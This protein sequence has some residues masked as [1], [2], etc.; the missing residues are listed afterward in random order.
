MPQDQEAESRLPIWIWEENLILEH[1]VYS[2][3]KVLLITN[4]LGPRAGGIE[5]F[6]LG[7]IEGLPKNSLII[8][9]SS[10]KGDKAFDAQLLEK[11]GAVVI[12][13]RA[14]ML[15]PTPRITRK[16]VT[17]LRQQQIKNVWFGAAAPLALM[18]GKLRSAGASNIV[19]LT[20]GHEVWWAKIP[21]LQSLLKK[22]IRDV[23]HLGYLGEFTK[24]EIAK[25]G[26]QPQKF[27]Q[28]APGIDTQHFAPK[29]ARVDLIE[30][31]RLD[32]RRVIVSVG[33]LVHRKGQDE[34]VKAMPKILKQFPDAI[35]LF[36]GEG[37]I[38]QMLFNSAKQLGVLPKV[39]FAGRVSHHDLPDY[40]CLGEIFAM[41][42]RSRFSG[43]EVEGLGIVYLEASACGLPVIVGNSGGAVDAVLDRKTGLLVDGTNCDQ[44]ADAICELLANP[45][46]A[47]QMGAAGRDWVIKNWQLSSWSEKFN[48]VLIGN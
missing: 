39:V 38:K 6:V 21:I 9:T 34:L 46:R 35:L 37:P 23:D 27:L 25:V 12:R 8:Y 26:H 11:F 16:A 5:T 47:K 33:R 15:L 31:Y 45:E 17:I 1:A 41:P 14:K 7:L 22:I 29:S 10:Q 42:V 30:K 19:A 3:K 36:V 20:H 44:I 18:A 24:G 4:D 28:I 48:K 2:D 32:G 40:I 43:L 13:D